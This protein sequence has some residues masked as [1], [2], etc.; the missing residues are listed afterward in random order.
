VNSYHNVGWEDW[1][2]RVKAYSNEQALCKS[3]IWHDSNQ[4]KFWACQRGSYVHEIE[5]MWKESMQFY[6]MREIK[7]DSPWNEF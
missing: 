6:K 2:L 3:R 7:T 5:S 4:K 1:V